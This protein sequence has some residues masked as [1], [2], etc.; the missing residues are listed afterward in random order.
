MN[1]LRLDPAD[2]KAVR[3]QFILGRFKGLADILRQIDGHKD[4]DGLWA[5]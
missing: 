1:I 2:L 5:A 4:S 3:A